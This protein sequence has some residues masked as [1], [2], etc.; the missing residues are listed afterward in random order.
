VDGSTAITRLRFL[1]LLL[2]VS[3]V[4]PATACIGSNATSHDSPTHHH[5][6]VTSTSPGACLTPR[7][8]Y[9]PY[10]GHDQGLSQIPWV[11]GEPPDSE[12]VALL[13]YWPE[14]WTRRHLREARIFTAGV[15]PAGYNVK[16]LWMFL[17]PLAR[18][19][20]GRNLVVQGHQLDGSATFRQ[21]P[22]SRISS[23]SQRGA[24]SYASII[25]VPHTGCWRLDLKSRGLSG[26][27]QFRAVPGRG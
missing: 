3:G 24:P 25:N 27:V 7:V 19:R 14:A 12:L 1:A 20:A 5:A 8:Q 16:I 2:V 9:R 11:R 26:H 15:A 10:P 17:A 21:Q 13:W 18:S 6:T 4:V 22:F 23:P